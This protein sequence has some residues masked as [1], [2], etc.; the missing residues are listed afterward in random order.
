MNAKKTT[1]RRKY[2]FPPVFAIDENYGDNQIHQLFRPAYAGFVLV[3]PYEQLECR[4]FLLTPVETDPTPIL[5]IL[6]AKQPA[7]RQKIDRVVPAAFNK[8]LGFP[9]L[10]LVLDDEP[11]DLSSGTWIRHPGIVRGP[12]DYPSRTTEVLSSWRGA[13]TLAEEE[14]EEHLA[15]L[16]S[17]QIGAIHAVY[18]HW[19]ASSEAAT[20][21]MPTGTGK[22]EVM[23]SVLVSQRCPRLLVIVPTDAL[24]T[25]IGERF[26]SHGILKEISVVSDAAQYPLVGFLRNRPKTVDEVD[27]WF[28]KCNVVVT[29]MNVAG[30][31]PDE[32][33]KQMASCCSHLFVDEA[34]HLGADTWAAFKDH[35]KGNRILQFTATPFRNDD[36]LVEGKIIFNYP[37]KKALE[38]GYFKPIHFNPVEEYDP[39]QMDRSIVR[40]AVAQLE[41][42]LQAGYNHILMARV[43]TTKRAEEVFALYANHPEF[44]PVQLHTEIPTKEREQSK[45][46][47]KSGEARI[48]VCVDMLGEGFDLPELKIAAFH[49]IKKSLPVTLQLT[50]RFTRAR[51]DLGEPTVI[52]NI[53][54]ADV[55]D[56][57]QKLYSQDADW[58]TLLPQSSQ[59]V[60][61]R[62]VDLL[63]FL[64]GFKDKPKDIPLQ[65]LKPTLYT[66]LYRTNCTTWRPENF[67]NGIENKSTIQH[68]DKYINYEKD[69]MVIL[70]ARKLPVDWADIQE[71]YTLEWEL[72]I[73][74]WDREQQILFINSSGCKGYLKKLA[75]AVMGKEAITHIKDQDVIRCFSGV[76]R[77]RIQSL[78]VRSIPPGNISY[79][80]YAGPDVIPGLS[81]TQRSK[82]SA[83]NLSGSG[84]EG[85]RRVSMGCSTA[86]RVWAHTP[87]NISSLIQGCQHVGEKILDASIDPDMVLKGV[88][89]PKII[90][91]RPDKMPIG[92]EWPELFYLDSEASYRFTLKQ[93][94]MKITLP[95]FN[96]DIRL[97]DPA[98]TGD[99]RFE[100]ISDS[101]EIRREFTLTIHSTG[102]TI[103]GGKALNI[104]QGGHERLLG[105][106]FEEHPPTIWFHDGSFLEGDRFVESP[107]IYAPYLRENLTAWDWAG[108]NIHKESQVDLK[109]APQFLEKEADSIQYHVIQRMITKKDT[110]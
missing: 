7:Q 110:A 49:D 36:R 13:F 10:D 67:K 53:G 79:S 89:V 73:L 42:D 100:V 76:T 84:Y 97:V 30:Q 15:G 103:S 75:Q 9:E 37:L 63:E 16:R 4:G 33:Q 106:F 11:V 78:G 3:E 88:L 72:I 2:L 38:N 93:G 31:C 18:A 102:Y 109:K 60:I 20:I 74:Y 12:V 25:Q 87:K 57:L 27:D 81:T 21:V 35:F 85:G 6:N 41:E 77:L 48:I 32:V 99:I 19:A 83:S 66:T 61:K 108:V 47:I 28:K 104:E 52:A 80:M 92:I 95:I 1:T 26:L 43:E 91:T 70:L 86:G 5:L 101:E 62:Q 82:S 64:E 17:P 23:L 90:K 96:T 71:I 55:R 94:K 59:A 8:V 45:A 34:H 105:T 65:N 24:R 51:T 44:N 54:D 46:K 107:K 14:T 56:E 50:G 58:N 29:T 22:T 40:Q 69:T 98:T 68:I 39:M